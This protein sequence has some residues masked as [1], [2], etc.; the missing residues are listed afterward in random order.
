MSEVTNIS[1]S[2]TAV[3]CGKWML[4]I[5]VWECAWIFW[6][7]LRT[8]HSILLYLVLFCSALRGGWIWSENN[9]LLNFEVK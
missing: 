5:H 4:H 2:Q 3:I 1:I 9:W 6:N 8:L 7:N